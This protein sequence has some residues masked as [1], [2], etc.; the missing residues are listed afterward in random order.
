MNDKIQA[1][2]ERYDRDKTRLMDILWDVQRQQGYISEDAIASIGE[3]LTM[4][5]DDVSETLT[6]Y[7]FFLDKPFGKH[8]VYL[9]NTV[10]AKM[11]GYDQLRETLMQETGCSFGC[12][13][14]SGTFGLGDANC[15][16]LSDQEPAMMIDDVVFTRLDS[17][18]VKS[19][20]AQLKQG[21]TAAEIANPDAVDSTDLGYVEAIVDANIQTQ[22]KVLFKPDRNYKAILQKESWG[23]GILGTQ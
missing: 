8:Q 4:S 21:K 5:P 17:N 13:D 2:L 20:V 22:S 10:I 7:H 9:C 16:G 18:K 1:I 19:I 14:R 11:H 3:G 12:V 23:H 15:I 6:F